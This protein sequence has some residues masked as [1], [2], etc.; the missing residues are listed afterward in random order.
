MRRFIRFD[1]LGGVIGEVSPN[2][3]V[4]MERREE[5]NGEHSLEITTLQVL[6]KNER[7]VYQDGRGIWREYVVVGIDEEHASGN[8]IVGTYYAVWSVMPDLM[9]VPVSVM[10]GVD[11]P[12]TAGVALS[13]LLSAQER[14]TRGTV[15]QTT[16]A[17]AS[18]YDMNA[19]KAVDV[20]LKNWGGELS[21]TVGVAT[22]SGVITRKVDLYSHLGSTTVTRR[23]DFG[24]D[25]KSVKR[26]MPDTPL[27][28]RIS[29]R[30]A[31]EQSGAGYGRKI[32]IT[33]V[34]GGRDYLE[35]APMVDVAKLP[36]GSNGYI[37]PTVIIENSN[38]KTPA[39]LLAWARG[40]LESA[41]TPKVTYE[42]D[43]VQAGVEGVDVSGV[44]LGDDVQ[45]VDRYFGADGLR[46]S[47]RV[48]SMTVDELN[49]REVTVK[50]GDIDETLSDT[51]GRM[52]A[53]LSTVSAAVQDMNG[54]TL[55]TADYLSNLLQ[56]LNGEINATGG[57][58]YITE[59]QGLRTYD[60]AVSD[61]L[62]GDEAASV[63][64]IKGGTIRIANSR[65]S[66]GDWDWKTV[67][68]SGHI[69]ANL[70]TAANIVTGYI[71]SS[72]GTYI[73]LD[74]N[75]VQLGAEDAVHIVLDND[76]FDLLMPNDGYGSTIMTHLGFGRVRSNY[77]IL[78]NGPYFMFGERRDG[79]IGY[80]SYSEGQQHLVTRAYSHAEGYNNTIS[81]NYSHAEGRGNSAS[82]DYSHAEG[83]ANTAS[84]YCA[85]V[86]GNGCTASGNY[87]MA[88]GSASTA[89]GANSFALGEGISASAYN[90]LIC[91]KY[92]AYH[93]GPFAVGYGSVVGNEKNVLTLDDDGDLWIAGTLRQNSDKRLKEHLAYLADDACEFVRKL[94]PALFSKDGKRHAGFYAQDVQDAE[95]GEWATETVTAQHTDESLDFDP[96]TLDYTAL[97]A[98]LVAYAQSLESRIEELESQL[99]GMSGVV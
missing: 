80:Y 15:T 28:C 50:I 76:A 37:Y 67:F 14:W 38:C 17:G 74:G 96:L 36:N 35:Y 66:S 25:I 53:Q 9:G 75:T 85:H 3:V 31:G 59:G 65:T 72:G 41:C 54:G 94:K 92:N 20:L 81:G 33:S 24:A 19:W 18:M 22:Q 29:P 43:A 13:S 10:P 4:S 88:H 16:A 89:S 1:H 70:V 56:R 51:L 91:G 40:Q 30:G 5:I 57:Y 60:R 62:V 52:K 64:E 87:S 71:G 99:E 93:S 61:P 78:V 2:D 84:G 90:Q 73:D 55:S 42:V 69:A 48:V 23:F 7:I 26:T 86:G 6:G 11:S 63:V 97:I 21:T 77:G 49:E 39:E 47:G 68:N 58:T 95:P 82:E 8:R 12:V 98:P 46:L 34:N 45:I 83:Y 79:D 27:Y 44:S 32:R